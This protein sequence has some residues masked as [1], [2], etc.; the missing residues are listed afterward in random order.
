MTSIF[1]APHNDDEV[2]FGSFLILRHRPTVVV[3]LASL[4]QEKTYGGPIAT[5]TIRKQESERALLE[6]DVLD[7]EQWPYPDVNPDWDAVETSMRAIDDRLMPDQVFAPAVEDGGH[8]Q[9]NA[10]GDRALRVFGA[11]VQ[12]YLTYKR[13][14][15]RSRAE[16]VPFEPD[17]PARKLRALSYFRSQII[18][19][20]TRPWF[21]DD[22]LREYVPKE[23]V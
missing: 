14:H 12:P 22:T 6:L 8:D 21:M 3:V 19:P 4:V 23:P 16:E 11:R 5:A 2:L 18:L 7:F 20:Q 9:H 1:F 13:G 17:W 10:V 15:L